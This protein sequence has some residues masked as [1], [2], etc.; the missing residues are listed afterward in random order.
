M[1]ELATYD[2]KSLTIDIIKNQL[3]KKGDPIPTDHDCLKFIALC[4]AHNLNPFIN[5]AYLIVAR[6][7]K[8]SII[9]SIAALEKR[10]SSSPQ[11]DGCT[12][13]IIVKRGKDIVYQDGSFKLKD[14]V[15]LGGWAKAY[16]KDQ[17]HTQ[18]TTVNLTE[19]RG[20]TPIWSQ[21]TGI[22]IEK[23]AE[24]QALRKTF[25]NETRGMYTSEEMNVDEPKEVEYVVEPVK[26]IG[27]AAV[28]PEEVKPERDPALDPIRALIKPFAAASKISIEDAI[29]MICSA[30][31][32]KGMN[33]LS[34]KMIKET[35]EYMNATI[36]AVSKEELAANDIE[37]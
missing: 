30:Q 2:P 4:K 18:L 7:G 19:Y 22:M 1:N 34:G 24:A 31:N 12:H 25:V 21:K 11:F 14:D 29:N 3:T 23:C 37:F 6:N 17:A 5:D 33:E 15:I 27:P 9:T 16:R 13:G 35:V 28:E 26:T 36:N 20:N 8:A 32:V 10:A